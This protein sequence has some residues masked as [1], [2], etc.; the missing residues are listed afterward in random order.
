MIVIGDRNAGVDIDF[1]AGEDSGPV[2]QELE[3]R[4]APFEWML[5]ATSSLAGSSFSSA[6]MPGTPEISAGETRPS[7]SDYGLTEA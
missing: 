1:K 5:P 2:R 6:G 3:T 7:R 4:N